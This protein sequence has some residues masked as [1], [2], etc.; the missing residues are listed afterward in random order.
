MRR[1]RDKKPAH[2][3]FSEQTVPV[4]ELGLKRKGI[5]GLGKHLYA[6]F[7][8]KDLILYII[9][10]TT[11]AVEGVFNAQHHARLKCTG[12]LRA[13]KRCFFAG[14]IATNG[15]TEMSSYITGNMDG[16]VDAFKYIAE[17]NARA[18]MSFGIFVALIKLGIQSFPFGKCPAANGIGTGKV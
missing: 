11:R 4:F 8:N 13:D 5:R 12:F 6:V 14:N 9:G 17:A 16:I 1:D 2:L 18:N 15:M 10:L 7:S 3:A